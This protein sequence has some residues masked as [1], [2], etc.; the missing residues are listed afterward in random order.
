MDAMY[1]RDRRKMGGGLTEEGQGRA[2]QRE[3]EEGINNMKGVWKA[4]GKSIISLH[5]YDLKEQRTTS[6]S[7]GRTNHSIQHE[8]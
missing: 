1:E 3:R 2:L 7:F 6:Q 8:Y 4:T 5:E